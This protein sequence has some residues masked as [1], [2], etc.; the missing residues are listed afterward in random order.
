MLLIVCALYFYQYFLRISYSVLAPHLSAYFHL[1]PTQVSNIA[2]VF[3]Y[4]FITIQIV[5]GF[6]VDK[7]GAN[8][9]LVISA[10][11]TA[12]SCLL[13]AYANNELNE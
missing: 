4:T 7:F 6:L 8:I 3:F 2:A 12:I 11:L 10:I 5:E 13:I 1:D 9:M